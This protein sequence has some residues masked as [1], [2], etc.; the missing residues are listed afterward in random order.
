MKKIL[1]I[2]ALI[3][4]SHVADAQ[5]SAKVG[6]KHSVKYK[7]YQVTCSFTPIP[8]FISGDSLFSISGVLDD[9]PGKVVNFLFEKHSTNKDASVF[10]NENNTV[11]ALLKSTAG[12]KIIG[13]KL[14]LTEKNSLET[15][16]PDLYKTLRKSNYLIP[17]GYK[18]AGTK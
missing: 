3:C 14:T 6:P 9:H 7:K 13:R 15:R 12:F 5:T 18:E 4:A 11:D 2:C 16:Y 17:V 1:L 10:N 8:N